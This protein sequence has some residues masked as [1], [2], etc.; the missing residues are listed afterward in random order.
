[1]YIVDVLTVSRHLYRRYVNWVISCI[2]QLVRNMLT[3]SCCSC[4]WH[5]NLAMSTL[6]YSDTTRDDMI[7]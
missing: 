7:T 5:D 4:G 1:M 3:W 2:D 6:L